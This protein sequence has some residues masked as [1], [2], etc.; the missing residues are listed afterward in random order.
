MFSPEVTLDITVTGP[1][2]LAPLARR[3]YP[4]LPFLALLGLGALYRNRRAARTRAAIEARFNPYTVGAAVE[5][6]DKFFGRQDELSRLLTALEHGNHVA[7]YGSR[8]IG[9]T[10]LLHRL[11]HA[12]EAA[13]DA[14]RLFIPVFVSLQ[15]V[16]EERFFYALMHGVAA[17]CRKHVELPELLCDSRPASYDSL[18]M[19]ED[20]ETVVRAMHAADERDLC[21]VLLL[22]EAD[23][24]NRYDEETQEGLRGLLMTS[25]GRHV[26]LVWSGQAIDREWHLDTSP[27]YNLFKDEIRLMAFT[28]EQEA[29]RLVTQ[30]V[31][32][33][34]KYKKDAVDLILRYS[35]LRPYDIQRLCSAC[36]SR[37]LAEKR[38]RSIT[39][40]DVEAAHQEMIAEDERKATEEQA[41][42]YRLT[43][44]GQPVAESSTEYSVDEEGEDK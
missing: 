39:V 27:W 6:A 16:P 11:A 7:I 15:T 5:E 26:K 14:G 10:S 34:Y 41:T 21:I 24:M 36:V 4:L 40:E 32:G 37:I 19:T 42:G 25:A 9:K 44:A 18:D 17:A 30:P 28:D 22:D 23:R 38:P 33:R 2:Y 1:W 31:E 12:L 35:E 43:P 8:R 3:L 29:R 13:S 20:L